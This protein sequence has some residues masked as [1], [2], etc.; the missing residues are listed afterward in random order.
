MTADR[1]K[2]RAIVLEV[3]AILTLILITYSVSAAIALATFIVGIYVRSAPKSLYFAYVMLAIFVYTVGYIF[4]ILA[5]SHQSALVATMVQYCGGAFISPL[6]FFFVCEYCGTK[7]KKY[8]YVCLLL[9]PVLACLLLWT[10][11]LNGIYY[12][13]L[14]FVTTGLVPHFILEGSFFYYLFMGYAV[15]L[16]LAAIAVLLFHFRRRESLFKTQAVEIILTIVLATILPVLSTT[17]SLIFA[18]RLWLNTTPLILSFSCLLLAYSMLQLGLY[19]I[20]PLAREKII[21]TMSD[22]FV[23]IDMQGCYVDANSEAKRL[24]PRLAYTS[25]GMK[26]DEVE[27]L[28]WLSD[29][30]NMSGKEFTLTEPGGTVKHYRISETEIRHGDKP[31]CRCLMIYDSTNTRQI[32]DEVSS[33]AEHDNLTDLMNRGAFS[34]NSK[35]MIDKIGAS[36]GEACLLMIDLD[37]FKNVNDV[38]GHLKGDEVLKTMADLLIS[39]FRA[40]DLVARYG[41]E[42]FCVLLPNI[43]EENALEIAREMRL[44]A[45]NQEFVADGEVFHSTLS[46]GLAV[47]DFRRH[48]QL[49]SLLADADAALYA[50]KNNGRNTIY[51]ARI[52][53]G[54]G[55]LPEETWI[56]LERAPDKS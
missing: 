24:L 52:A 33:L 26:L 43:S 55:G 51:I 37:C 27:D 14:E 45:A 5:E 17:C 12:H 20:A 2:Q 23:L 41:G 22:G 18:D 28:A 3:V 21:E 36:G 50:A 47:Y 46:I 7:L 9:I 38:Y 35:L 49:E 48:H 54:S 31:I 30:N 6:M 11:P 10:Y 34:R 39:R 8:H 44:Q 19:R 42:E 56:T 4:E 29:E 32:L 16:P 25:I 13:R 53:E 40:T 1:R 15:L